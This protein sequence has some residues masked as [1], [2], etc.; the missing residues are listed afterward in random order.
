MSRALSHKQERM[1]RALPASSWGDLTDRL[2]TS[3]RSEY[4]GATGTWASLY[5]RGLAEWRKDGSLY[6]TT[7]GV[8]W[9]LQTDFD[10][11]HTTAKEPS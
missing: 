4:G 5:Q 8:R 6:P 2:G 3:G 7:D 10:R 9:L 11:Q 1:L